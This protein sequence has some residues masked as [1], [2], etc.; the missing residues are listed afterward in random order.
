VNIKTMLQKPMQVS[1]VAA[2]GI[3]DDVIRYIPAFHDLINKVYI[4]L[5]QNSL[6][7]F[8]IVHTLKYAQLRLKRVV[9][10]FK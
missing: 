5:A 7:A 1:A 4:S 8:I 2:T 3:Q 9:C 10:N 6:K